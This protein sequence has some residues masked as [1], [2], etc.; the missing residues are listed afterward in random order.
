M[1]EEWKYEVRLWYI[2][3]VSYTLNAHA[4][5]RVESVNVN[6]W[7]KKLI[8]KDNSSIFIFE[9]SL[10]GKREWLWGIEELPILFHS[11]DCIPLS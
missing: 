4:C 10:V 5:T 2:Q 9:I 8:F 1:F 6:E 7:N 3:F 11:L